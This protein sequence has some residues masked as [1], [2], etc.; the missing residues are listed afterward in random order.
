MGYNQFSQLKKPWMDSDKKLL[1]TVRGRLGQC[2][3]IHEKVADQERLSM[4]SNA[5]EKSKYIRIEVLKRKG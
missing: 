4:M 2:C 3:G 5:A 1:E